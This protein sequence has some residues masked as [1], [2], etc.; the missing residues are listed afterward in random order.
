MGILVVS[1]LGARASYVIRNFPYF[2]EHAGQIPQLWLGGLTWPG[3]VI[4]AGAGLWGAHQIW[5]EP[6]GE[7]A[8]R[9]LPLF[10]IMTLVIWITGWALGMG[11]GPPTDAWFGIPVKDIFGL[12]DF[13]W[14]LNIIGAVLS[15]G[16]IAGSILFPLK[17]TRGAGFRAAVGLTGIVGITGLISLFRVD[18]AP[19]LIG[20]RW[21]T[22]TALVFL[23]VI[24]GVYTLKGKV[25]DDGK[26]K[27]E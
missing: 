22:W 19:R 13:R 25:S 11:Y 4:G 14:P 2:L 23:G 18:P 26:V 3:A 1:L 7:L 15:G 24:A 16:W 10:G 8:D 6:I 9:L 20:L 12:K 17:R 27:T 21:E 5:K